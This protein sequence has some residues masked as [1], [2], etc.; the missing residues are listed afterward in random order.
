[1]DHANPLSVVTPSLDGP[2][3]L[4]LS[5]TTGEVTGR[6]V[7]RLA[8]VGSSD[9]VRKVLARLVRQGIVVAREQAHA[10]L[11]QLNR[12][13][14]AVEAILELTRLRGKIIDQ[15]VAEITRWAIGPL[16][17]SFYGSFARS[18]ATE[19]SDLDLLV[20]APESVEDDGLWDKQL[21]ELA[22]LIRL[23]TGNEAHVVD[24]TVEALTRMLRSE[25]P[26]LQSWRVDALHLCGQPLMD[27]LREL[28]TRAGLP[29]QGLT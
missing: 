2:V 5:A 8:G 28:R 11:Y 29:W 22:R 14:V 19:G 1:M 9:G 12:K 21:D 3:L 10:T 15:T 18:E 7:H 26:L 6:Q 24:V 25:D 13:H 23:W 27:L 4:A 17:A 20:V 16:H